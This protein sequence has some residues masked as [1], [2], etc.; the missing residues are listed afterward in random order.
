MLKIRRHVDLG[1]PG[2]PQYSTSFLS[3]DLFFFF[4]ISPSLGEV[5]WHFYNFEIL[6]VWQFYRLRNMLSFIFA[7]LTIA[8]INYTG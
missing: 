3:A 7:G 1:V 4:F 2:Q 5:T 8:N 6:P